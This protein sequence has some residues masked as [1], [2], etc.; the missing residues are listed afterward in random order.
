M[1][2]L[3]RDLRFAWRSLRRTPVVTVVAIVSIALGIAA[4][5]S[6]FSV[7]DAALFRPPPLDQSDRL[8]VLLM[9][10]EEPGAPARLMRWSWPRT[11]ALRERVRS[12]ERVA[13]FSQSVLALTDDVPEPVTSEVVSSD[14]WPLLH[15]QPM[16]GRAF[17]A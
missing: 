16:T 11:R 6:V 5:T 1:G 4:T 2:T 13:S 7:V 9:T 8:A 10:S 15:V 14:Y 12:F 3:G 17:S